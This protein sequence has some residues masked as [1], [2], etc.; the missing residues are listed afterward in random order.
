[1]REGSGKEKMLNMIFTF[2]VWVV[3]YL[4]VLFIKKERINFG[5]K[6]DKFSFRWKILKF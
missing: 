6:G 2:T 3:E 4:V 1:M 5:V